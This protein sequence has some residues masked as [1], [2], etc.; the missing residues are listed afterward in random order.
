MMRIEDVKTLED[1]A[2]Y[3]YLNEAEMQ[4][5]QAAL[6]PLAESADTFEDFECAARSVKP[7]NAC[8][9]PEWI[10]ILIGPNNDDDLRGYSGS[11]VYG[12][13]DDAL[14]AF[15]RVWRDGNEH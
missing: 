5:F 15:W 14:H 1:F 3:H 8:H 7:I 2:K 9:D 13:L 11:I 4:A 10:E 12:V 6:K